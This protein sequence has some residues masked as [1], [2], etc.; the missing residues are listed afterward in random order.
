MI[1]PLNLADSLPPKSQDLSSNATEPT[2]HKVLLKIRG[3]PP[4]RPSCD[5][6]DR[7]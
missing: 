1:M 2:L 7:A 5:R 4:G 6:N 3:E